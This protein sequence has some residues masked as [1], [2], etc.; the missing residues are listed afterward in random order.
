MTRKP[1]VVSTMPRAPLAARR[2]Q[3]DAARADDVD[4]RF[5]SSRAWRERLQTAQ[6]ARS[7][8]CSFCLLLG[9]TVSA[10]TVDHIT[11]PFG[12]VVLQ[13]SQ[14][15]FQSLC[16]YHHNVKSNWERS[17]MDKP[18]YLGL[19]KSG[20]RVYWTPPPRGVDETWPVF[21]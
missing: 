2:R 13:R 9:Y 11:R 3:Q 18:L 19:D 10:Q 14:Y 17:A 16:H 8:L 20:P 4:R 12:D 21:A 5:R 1:P 15:N 7:P 6:L